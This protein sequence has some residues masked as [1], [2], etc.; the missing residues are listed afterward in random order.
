MSAAPTRKRL[1]RLRDGAQLS[2]FTDPD[3]VRFLLAELAEAVALL[4]PRNRP[5]DTEAE[6]WREYTKRR[7]AWLKAHAG[8]VLYRNDGAGK[9]ER[10]KK[11][12]K[13]KQAKSAP[14]APV[15]R[16]WKDGIYLVRVGEDFCDLYVRGG[17]VH[18]CKLDDGYAIAN[19][20]TNVTVERWIELQGG[21]AVTDS[22]GNVT[23]KVR[24]GTEPSHH[25]SGT[26]VV[27]WRE[28]TASDTN[29]PKQKP[30]PKVEPKTKKQRDAEQI[31]K[32]AAG[33]KVPVARKQV[34]L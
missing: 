3:D 13:E 6:A 24:I 26:V 19:N 30:E 14:P 8:E 25:E 7:D 2:L 21:E 18:G 5:Y 34:T 20:V 1:A 29:K 27:G 32:A 16:E 12:Q 17:L 11:P 23:G 4:Q 10:A 31:I 15:A 22:K 9:V 28:W 33:G